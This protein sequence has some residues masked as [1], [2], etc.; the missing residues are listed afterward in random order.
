M[1]L[2]SWPADEHFHSRLRIGTVCSNARV[3]IDH[4]GQHIWSEA[5]VQKPKTE[6]STDTKSYFCTLLEG[7]LIL[8]KPF[9]LK[10]PNNQEA[11]TA[12]MLGMSQTI[13]RKHY[14]AQ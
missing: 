1:Q 7:F 2:K 8:Q 9:Q 14:G 13:L 11:R 10:G 12:V 6:Q 5:W 3:K 4:S